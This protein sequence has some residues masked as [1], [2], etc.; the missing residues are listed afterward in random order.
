LG[1]LRF[2]RGAA[3]RCLGKLN[4][5]GTEPKQSKQATRCQLYEQ[6]YHTLFKDFFL[7][8]YLTWKLPQ[9]V[10]V[11]LMKLGVTN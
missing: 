11:K 5:V 3:L 2:G 1:G 10:D 7:Q 6:C 4:S 9:N 8:Y